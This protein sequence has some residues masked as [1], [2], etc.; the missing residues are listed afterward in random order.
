MTETPEFENEQTVHTHTQN[1]T[2]EEFHASY[3]AAVEKVRKGLGDTHPLRIDGDSVETDET[4]TV[5]CPGDTDLV[6]GE[7]ASGGESDVE[8]A[9]RSAS[10]AFDGWHNTGWRKRAEVVHDAA[11]ELRERKYELAVTLTFENGKDRMEA[12]AETDEAIDFLEFYARELERNEGY[13]KDTGEPTPEQNCAN[14]L[15]PYGVFGVVSPFNF[16]LAIYA[17]MTTGALAMGNTV[18]TKPASDTP[19][20][21][22]KVVDALDDA[23]MPDGVLNLVT[24]GGRAVGEPLVEH[25]DVAGFVFTGS[26]E[27][28]LELER[29]F[30]ERG[31]RGPVVAE[32]GGKNPVVVTAEADLE[33]AVEGVKMGAFS[34]A[35]QKCS[36]TSRVYVQE[37]VFDAFVERL[38]KETDEI[39]FM[40]PEE[41]GAVVAPVI[42]ET[43]LERYERI[44]DVAR[45]EGNVL[46]GG[47]VVDVSEH[48]MPEGRYVKP[49]VVVD[50]PH[51]HELAR[52]EHFLPFVTVHPVA[53]LN[54]GIH[55]S[56]DSDYGLCAG[57][58]T[59]DGDEADEWLD[60]IESG[61]CYVN[62]ARS[63]TTGALV[64]VQPFGGWKHSG[65]TGKFAG[66]YHYLQQFA[67]EQTRTVVGDVYPLER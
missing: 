26:R 24:G 28:G 2:L 58:F 66:G 55:K 21:A 7:F 38:V 49:T 62:R 11:D 25:E 1:G 20:V 63:A 30:R 10:E 52:E 9:V 53:D 35:G 46:T 4:F 67:R 3:D 39:P 13:A 61:M 14:V 34:F 43:A 37:T 32:L 36:A 31:K 41:R 23:G 50:V 45:E 29:K 56:N 51:E 59:E 5:T 65:T 16:P 44:C 54:E 6:I 40:R 12:M 57:L 15:R 17:G 64:G 8:H 22:H 42:D 48:D 18:V 27:V 19:L 33:K 47:E 60:R